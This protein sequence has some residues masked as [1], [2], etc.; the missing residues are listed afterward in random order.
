[1]FGDNG[2]EIKQTNHTF[3]SGASWKLHMQGTYMKRQTIK[4]ST[5]A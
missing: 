2:P 5:V 1:M 3:Q 4:Y